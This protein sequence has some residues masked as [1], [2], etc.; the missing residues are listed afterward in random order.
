[1]NR[2][3]EKPRLGNAVSLRCCPGLQQRKEYQGEKVVNEKNGGG[4]REIYFEVSSPVI[5]QLI[6]L[7]KI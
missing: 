1:M 4:S 7:S 5:F 2:E 6:F 3:R